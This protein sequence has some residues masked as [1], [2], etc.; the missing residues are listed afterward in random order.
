MVSKQL[1]G[2]FSVPESSNWVD[3]WVQTLN[4]TWGRCGQ[5]SSE[6]LSWEGFSVEHFKATAN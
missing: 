4:P 3:I 1:A 5:T 6:P 2:K